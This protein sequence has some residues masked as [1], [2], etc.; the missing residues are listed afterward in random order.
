VALN[1]KKRANCGKLM[2]ICGK[3]AQYAS[4]DNFPQYD[5]IFSKKREQARNLFLFF[6]TAVGTAFGFCFWEAVVKKGKKRNM[7]E[8]KQKI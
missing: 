4:V 5:I 3:L 7:K 6:V 2:L 8:K 1:I